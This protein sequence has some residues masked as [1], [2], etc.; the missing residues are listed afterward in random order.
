MNNSEEQTLLLIED[1]PGDSRLIKEMWKEITSFNYQLIIAGTLKDGCDL[2]RKRNLILILLDL[3]LPDSTGKQTYDTVMKFANNIPVVLVSGLQ[4]MEL[5]ISLIKEG[6]QDY[7]SKQNLT[8]SLLEKT[9]QYAISR[10]KAEEDI[11]E[12]EEKFS[13]AFKTSPY[14]IIITR[15]KDGRFIEV[16]EAF[17]TLTG[18][19]PEDTLNSTSIEMALWVDK[20][21]RESVVRNL[22]GGG[23][24]IAQEF[25]FKKKNGEVIIGL[26]SAQ[27]I[28]INNDNYILSSIDDITRRKQAEQELII[29]MEHAQESDRL[30]S[31]FLCN[32]SH[33]IRTPMNGIL[34]FANL[35]KEPDLAIEEQKKYISIIEKSSTRLLNIVTDIVSISKIESGI[36][37]ISVSE[38]NL[39]EKIEYLYSFFRPEAEQKGIQLLYKN[40]LPANEAIIITDREKLTSI[41]TNLIKNAI[42]F[43][44]AGS[45]EFGYEKKGKYLEF[46]VKDT[47]TGIHEEQKEIIFERFRQGSY[48]FNRNDAGTGLGLSISKAYTEM[49]GGKIRVE[50]ELG[51]GSIFYFT[52]PYNPESQE[53]NII[54]DAVP[55]VVEE[56]QI[57]NLKILIAEDD[58]DS[59]M[60]ISRA[61]KIFSKELLK[62]RT[63][64]AAVE[65]CRN[66]PDI[67]LILMDVKMPDM[68]GYEATKQIR[69]FNKDVIIIAQTA[70]GLS[71]DREKAIDAGCN[72]YISKPFTQAL[73]LATIHS[74]FNK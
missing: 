10:M 40:S 72:D 55:A 31:A 68:D 17:F 3:N 39:N 29:A 26:L 70:F 44:E 49:L 32:M 14:A 35:L 33:E 62:V 45:I 19:A 46:F 36:L 65:A 5:A 42:K 53:K 22:M 47:G 63:G 54:K 1:N 37:E 74:H 66:N 18:Y 30:K 64:V 7:I 15:P 6:A 16:N 23:K 4:D 11:R 8:S 24:I 71:G 58:E 12:S 48:S 50:S 2:I 9:I 28:H 59:Q 60:L 73:L 61:V 41:L 20:E 27:I 56:N 21:D 43:T 13:I 67:D 57:N 34:G 38:S 52:I 69:Q 51:K 25:K